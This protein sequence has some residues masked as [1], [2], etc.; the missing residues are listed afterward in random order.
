MD[1]LAEEEQ[2]QAGRIQGVIEMKT[3]F[4]IIGFAGQFF[5]FMRFFVQ[6]IASE[7]KKQ[8]YIPRIFWYFSIAGSVLLLSYAVWRKDPVFIVG[9]SVG[10]VVYT[11]NLI[12]IAAGREA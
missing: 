12:L 11:R 7:I 1:I 10:I 5:F 3:V 6:W 8:S 4:I 9:Q 2:F